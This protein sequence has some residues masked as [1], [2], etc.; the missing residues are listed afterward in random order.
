MNTASLDSR[1]RLVKFNDMTIN[2]AVAYY[3]GKGIQSKYHNLFLNT[4]LECLKNGAY[5]KFSNDEINI[6][7]SAFKEGYDFRWLIGDFNAEG[8]VKI[9]NVLRNDN[10]AKCVFNYYTPDRL[11]ML[12]NAVLTDKNIRPFARECFDNTCNGC[13]LI[14]QALYKRGYNLINDEYNSKENT[15][16]ADIVDPAQDNKFICRMNLRVDIDT[17]VSSYLEVH[18]IK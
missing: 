13:T 8:M 4:I 1:G 18:G 12:Q 15:F 14:T 2:E 17:I 16:I 7:M 10:I 11:S 5:G 3:T 9:L 6:L